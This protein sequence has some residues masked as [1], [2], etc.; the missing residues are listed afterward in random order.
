M[1]PVA[2]FRQDGAGLEAP[3]VAL[4]RQDVRGQTKQLE[5]AGQASDEGVEFIAISRISSFCKFC[6]N[7]SWWGRPGVP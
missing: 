3:P 7:V 4:I 2:L 1:I 6:Q 5:A